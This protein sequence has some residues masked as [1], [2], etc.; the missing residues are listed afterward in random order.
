LL[1]HPFVSPPGVLT[2]ISHLSRVRNMKFQANLRHE[3][4][5]SHGFRPQV[6]EQ[7]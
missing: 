3:I 5:G 6:G 2:S 7:K 4:E 1:K